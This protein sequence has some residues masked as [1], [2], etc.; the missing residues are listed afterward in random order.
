MI[1]LAQV[2]IE[3]QALTVAAVDPA[4]YR[5]YTPSQRAETQVVWDRVAAGELAVRPAL[6]K[7]LPID[8]QGF[9]RLGST[10]DAARV[11][12]GALAPQAQQ[13][14]AVV[15]E[16]WINDAP[17]DARQRAADPHR[18][19]RRRSRC[20]SRSSGCSGTRPPCR[21]P[22]RSRASASTPT[23]PRPPWWSAP[24]PTRWG[25]SATPSSAAAGSRPS[26]PGSPRTSRPARSRSS[27][28][29]PATRRSS[30]SSRPRCRRCR[31]RGLA[32]KIHPGE[33]AGCYY[34]R[35]IAGTTKLSNHSFGLALDLN[36][37]GNQRGTA[38]EIDRD[39]VAI[40]KS[41]GFT[42]GGDWGYTDPMHFEMNTLVDPR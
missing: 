35:F 41:W 40:F 15:N 31:H 1:S 16:T 42:W 37:P 36:V 13:I 17:H 33:Y 27:A 8:E 4:T 22:T 6:E 14:D 39:V 7:K 23:Q 2:P 18:Q 34:P 29:S 24:S 11:H 3:N 5:N 32:D 20:A 10:E 25:S 28:A 21:W 38:G 30:R 9:L 12:V 19:H 26:P